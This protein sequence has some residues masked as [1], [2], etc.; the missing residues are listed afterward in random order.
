MPVQT[1]KQ[2]VLTH[3]L[4]GRTLTQGEATVLG[5]GTR[6]AARVRDLRRDGHKIV[7]TNKF[8]IHGIPYGEYRLI[9]RKGV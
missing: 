5:Y 6:L 2:Q 4:S 8:D 3:L 9:S 1:R 7:T